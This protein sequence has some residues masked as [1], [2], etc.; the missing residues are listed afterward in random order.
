MATLTY[1]YADSTAV[2][3][4]LATFAEPHAYDLCTQHA[5]SLTVPRGWEVLRLA[6]PSTPPQPGPDDLLALANA[7]REAASAAPE[8]PARHNHTQMEPPTSVEGTRRGH[9]RILREP[10]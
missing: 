1:V 3:G 9:L 4:P 2:L 6:M 10:S 5:E 7:V 8:T